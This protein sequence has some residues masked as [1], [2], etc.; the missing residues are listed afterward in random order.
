MANNNTDLPGATQWVS[1]RFNRL[2]EEF[3]KTTEDVIQHSDDFPSW[4]ED[5]DR[6]VEAYIDMLGA[7]AYIRMRST[8]I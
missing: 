5:I 8:P 3:L 1:D 4:G 6:Q 7:F 2:V